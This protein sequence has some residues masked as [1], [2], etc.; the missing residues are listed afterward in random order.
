MEPAGD[1]YPIDKID[2]VIVPG[3]AFDRAGFRIGFGKGYYD[4][5]LSRLRP[6]TY[7][8]GVA[9]HFQLLD[10]VGPLP[11]DWPLQKVITDN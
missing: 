6:E 5:F 9:Y 3:V 1:A 7:T 11:H 4:R 2:V 10:D 8:L